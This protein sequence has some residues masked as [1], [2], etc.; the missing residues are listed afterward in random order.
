M[1]IKTDNSG[2]S[3]HGFVEIV[4]AAAG[5]VILRRLTHLL[6][7]LEDRCENE[8]SCC[9]ASSSFCGRNTALDSCDAMA[10]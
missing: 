10:V 5:A 9:A 8:V 7:R 3:I 1:R 6:S 2:R 4:I